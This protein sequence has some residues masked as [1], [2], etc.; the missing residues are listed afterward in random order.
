MVCCWCVVLKFVHYSAADWC[1][2]V[3]LRRYNWRSHWSLTELFFA[4]IPAVYVSC[5]SFDVCNESS[6]Q[7]P[8]S[9]V[10]VWGKLLQIKTAMLTL[11]ISFAVCR[12]G[13]DHICCLCSKMQHQQ[14]RK[15]SAFK[16]MSPL[17][18]RSLF[19]FL[20]FLLIVVLKWS[21]IHKLSWK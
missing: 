13:N 2:V 17:K 1:R 16:K 12:C 19:F 11:L 6:A 7:N 3:L 4:A 20:L 18:C 15:H 14:Q 8:V 9:T 10:T 5:F 21:E